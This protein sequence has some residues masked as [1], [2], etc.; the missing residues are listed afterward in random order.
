MDVEEGRLALDELGQ[1]L[2]AVGAGV[3]TRIELSQVEADLAE[4]G[5]AVLVDGHVKGALEQGDGIEL[6]GR[7]RAVLPILVFLALVFLLPG[8]LGAALSMGRSAPLAAPRL[9]PRLAVPAPGDKV[10]GIDEDVAA[11]DKGLGRRTLADA[12]DEEAHLPDPGRQAGIIAVARDDAE[13]VDQ[14]AMEDV[15]GVDDHGAVGGVLADG[16]AELL[17]GLDGV[18][19]ESVLP[20]RHVDR[21]PVAVDAADRHEAVLARLGQDL[22]D[23]RGLGV[24][25]V[26]EQGD[27]ARFFFDERLG[28]GG[29]LSSSGRFPPYISLFRRPVQPRPSGPFPSGSVRRKS[30]D[31]IPFPEKW[32]MSPIFRSGLFENF[33]AEGVGQ[34]EDR[35]LEVAVDGHPVPAP[36]VPL[37]EELLDVADGLDG[38]LR[39]AGPVVGRIGHGLALVEEDELAL[40]RELDGRGHVAHG[41]DRADRRALAVLRVGQ[42][43][44]GIRRSGRAE[45]LV[46]SDAVGIDDLAR[47]RVDD[48]VGD[49]SGPAVRQGGHGHHGRG[50]PDVALAAPDQALVDELVEAEAGIGVD[51]AAVEAAQAV[52]GDGVRAVLLQ[53]RFLA[54]VHGRRGEERVAADPVDPGRGL[55]PAVGDGRGLVLVGRGPGLIDLGEGNVEDLDAH[56][57]PDGRGDAGP[58]AADGQDLRVL[59]SLQAIPGRQAGRLVGR[60]GEVSGRRRSRP[61]GGRDEGPEIGGGAAL[62]HL[63]EGAAGGDEVLRPRR[64]D[65]AEVGRLLAQELGRVDE[66][67]AAAAVLE[68][69]IKGGLARPGDRLDDAV[70]A[71][72]LDDDIAVHGRPRVIGQDLLGL[73]LALGHGRGEFPA[74]ESLGQGQGRPVHDRLEVE[75]HVGPVGPGLDD[76]VEGVDDAQPQLFRPPAGLEEPG[77]GEDPQGAG[78]G[79][80]DKTAPAQGTA[81]TAA[82]SVSFIHRDLLLWVVLMAP[83][84]AVRRAPMLMQGR[85]GCQGNGELTGPG[86][87]VYSKPA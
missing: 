75:P 17:D 37:A 83:L 9:P 36:Q 71:I 52:D 7:V 65:E 44:E 59:H 4:I 86:E 27:F 14:V 50:R 76:G 32:V 2:E 58:A 35:L 61:P 84:S 69:D 10:L 54:E 16:I 62:L 73:L 55:L 39:P 26:D 21:R 8:L 19:V 64:R 3:E 12:H 60:H 79:G 11:V 43:L 56:L 85:R 15:H 22:P 82:G 31:T 63:G 80:R 51:M 1:L 67:P 33:P 77:R 13:A 42:D 49:V 30:G 5:P 53:D 29:V 74:R 34:L 57:L 38:E 81:G 68:V 47:G 23:E 6:G 87:N 25:A 45:G 18:V 78:R 48:R 46:R 28:H 41:Q 24:V 20:A 70:P 72:E 66:E 40:G